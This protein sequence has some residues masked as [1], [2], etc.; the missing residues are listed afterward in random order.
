MNMTGFRKPSCPP[1]TPPLAIPER[2]DLDFAETR[3]GRAVACAV[4]DVHYK[5]MRLN[6]FQLTFGTIQLDPNVLVMK[7]WEDAVLRLSSGALGTE[8]IADDP[9]DDEDEIVRW[10]VDQVRASAESH[11]NGQLTDEPEPPEDEPVLGGAPA[12]QLWRGGGVT[13]RR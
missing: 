9:V 11:E 6:I 8:A 7:G 5:P 3:A 10:F 2:Y 12:T 4:T 13:S 1:V